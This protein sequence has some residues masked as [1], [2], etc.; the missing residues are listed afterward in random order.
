MASQAF[1][2]C[3]VGERLVLNML[4]PDTGHLGPRSRCC[5]GVDW[6]LREADDIYTNCG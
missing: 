6:T 2:T 1:K 5:K 4:Q 3:K